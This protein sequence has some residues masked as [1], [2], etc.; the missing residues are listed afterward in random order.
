MTE[1]QLNEGVAQHM[2]EG[3]FVLCQ[4]DERGRPQS[5]VVTEEDLRVLLGLL[6]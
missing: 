1:V 4:K 3:V 2:G 6:A 5:V